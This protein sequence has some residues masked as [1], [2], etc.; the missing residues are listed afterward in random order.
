[1]RVGSMSRL[2]ARPLASIRGIDR[3]RAR[4]TRL[5]RVVSSLSRERIQIDFDS[6]EQLRREFDKNIANRGIFIPTT[7][8]FETR[9]RVIVDILLRDGEVDGGGLSLDGEVVHRIPP[10]MATSGAIPGVAIQL[11]ASAQVIR[12]QF[13]P[14]L[15]RAVGTAPADLVEVDEQGAGRRSSRRDAVR[16]PVR[17]MPAGSAPFEATSR[18]LSATGI[19]L[20][21]RG[22]A[23]PM[24]ETVCICLWHPN[25]ESSVEIDGQIVREIRNKT[26]RI[27]AVAVAFDR[28]QV[29]NARVGEV[30]EALRHAGHRSRM[31]GISGS[32]ADLGVAN[33]L[34]MFGSSAPRGTVVVERD[35]E[36]GWVAFAD[37]ALL[38]AELGA[39]EDHDALVAMLDWGDGRFAFEAVVDEM[40][41]ASADSRSLAGAILAAVCAVD[42]RD[43]A[44]SDPTSGDDGVRL[45]SE[46]G[47]GLALPCLEAGTRFEIVADRAQS[48]A[49]SFDK[50]EEAVVDLARSGLPLAKLFEII[51][52]AAPRVQS[53]VEAL[54]EAGVLRPR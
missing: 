19:L 23:L 18:D 7:E 20:S 12:E 9:Q 27:A 54:V 2:G 25:G 33:L 21:T 43:K 5:Y 45:P 3:G 48:L 50:I 30:I 8:P 16:V 46:A 28:L 36:Q 22:E 35:G 40:L 53:A 32:I 47:V 14:L 11:D 10:E 13:M 29:A 4:C 39:L 31:G 51:P 41:V 52:E 17:V 1:M 38:G 15:G 26:G 6:T 44:R 42:E 24:G 49:S 37:G 34:Q